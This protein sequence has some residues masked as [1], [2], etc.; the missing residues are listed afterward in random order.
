MSILLSNCS[1]KEDRGVTA[2]VQAGFSDE[3]LTA[4][5]TEL[6]DLEP[7]NKLH[8]STSSDTSSTIK[9]TLKRKYHDSY[10]DFGFAENTNNKP[11]CVICVKVF[12]NSSM[13]PAKMRR[14]FEWVHPE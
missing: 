12:P 9:K 8:S 4:D 13:F 7:S 10:L 1:A 5:A 6:L 3:S 2:S 11:Q 14:H